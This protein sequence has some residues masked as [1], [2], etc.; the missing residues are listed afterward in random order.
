VYLVS[1]D[2]TPYKFED[3][4]WS[5]LVGSGF[6]DVSV[7]PDGNP[8]AVNADKQIWCAEAVPPPYVP[9]GKGKR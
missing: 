6:T 2:G 1:P 5:R 3:G 9:P 7:K 8:C 4:G